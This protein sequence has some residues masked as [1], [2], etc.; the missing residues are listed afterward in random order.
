MGDRYDAMKALDDALAAAMTCFYPFGELG[1]PSRRKR[2]NAW[3]MPAVLIAHFIGKALV[4][5]GHDTPNLDRTS[6]VVRI[7]QTALTRMNY[8]TVTYT[9]VSKH[10]KSWTA[11]Y[12]WIG[13]TTDPKSTAI[14]RH[15]EI[16]N[17]IRKE[18]PL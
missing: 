7:V 5:S 16:M 3:H 15:N 13:E 11:K 18:Q 1:K 9:A 8:D 2:R 14:K 4:A 12:G 10:L 6:A 17:S